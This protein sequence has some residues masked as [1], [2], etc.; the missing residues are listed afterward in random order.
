MLSFRAVR[1]SGLS[2]VC[3]LAILLALTSLREEVGSQGANT[4]SLPAQLAMPQQLR[5][6]CMEVL[7]Q[8]LQSK[9][10]WPSMH[11]AEALTLAGC[12]AEVRSALKDRLQTEGDDQKRCGL[13]R[14]LARAG[15]R[16]KIAV[17]L[18]ILAKP[19]SNGHTHAAE[20][21]YKIGEIGDGRLLRKVMTQ[22]DKV[23][24]RLMALADLARCG[25]QQ[26]LKAIRER[27]MGTDPEGKDIAAWILARLGDKSDIPSLLQY[28]RQEK[29][30]VARSYAF[31]ALACLADPLGQKA[32]SKNLRASNP[33]VRTCA[34]EFAG[35]TRLVSLADR[36]TQLLSDRVL[37]VRIRSAHALIAL[38]LPAPDPNEDIRYDVY[39]ANS[40]NPRY[41]EGSIVVLLDGTL[42]YATTEFIGGGADHSAAQIVARISQ[43][44]GRTWGPPRVLQENVGKQ[45]VMSVSLRRLQ[46]PEREDTPLGMF[47][48]VKNGA[49][50]LK[51]YLRTSHDEGQ[52]FGP[53]I[54][55]TDQP[56]YHVMNN[57]RVALLS[58]GRLV[59]PVSWSPDISKQNHFVSFCYL[60]DDGGKSWRAGK[61]K[62]D[63]PKR[64]AMEPEVL[65]LTDGRLLMI[66]RTQ[67]G[68]VYASYSTDGGDSWCDP[69]S[70]GVKAPEAPATLRRIPSTGHLLLIWNNGAT[71]TPLTAAVSSDEGRTWEHTRNL[72]DRTDEAYAYTSLAFV[73]D[74]AVLSYYVRD[75]KSSRIS[76][77]FRS[78]PVRWFYKNG[79]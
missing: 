55:V 67:L 13:A 43:D 74:R 72:E 71:R 15:D 64:G 4:E 1:S 48:L 52:T 76:S 42:L 79:L 36:L 11:A 63:L 59:C 62:V 35:D 20:S 37:D 18:D 29:K 53:P 10:F 65:E 54:L 5:E 58:S 60:S 75:G 77:R 61:G 33:E 21:L 38:S 39:E 2:S 27:L 30:A 49:D 50:D 69:A 32:L 25:N 24:L 12:G 46:Q 44:G 57:D 16:S 26:A 31:H 73:R 17:L 45:N 51:A 47:Y 34:A 6:R 22:G 40:K 9:E 19:E 66:L 8:G 78:L 70:F 7:R 68:A 3:P 23:V 14:E 41:S 28:T 56:G